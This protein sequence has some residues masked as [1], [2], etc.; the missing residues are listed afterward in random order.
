VRPAL[1][2]WKTPFAD[3]APQLFVLNS[4]FVHVLWTF[5]AGRAGAHP[6]QPLATSYCI[7]TAIDLGFTTYFDPMI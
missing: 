7:N 1:H 4:L 2:V 3:Y 5:N 6:Y